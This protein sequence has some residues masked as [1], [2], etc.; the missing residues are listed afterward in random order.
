[1]ICVPTETESMIQLIR[2]LIHQMKERTRQYWCF[3]ASCSRHT[4][5][6]QN[7]QKTKM[8]DDSAVLYNLALLK[9]LTSSSSSTPTAPPFTIKPTLL[10]L[11]HTL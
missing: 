11:S 2:Q 8:E 7:W 10:E 9:I 1:M 4:T 6:T 5:G 3:F